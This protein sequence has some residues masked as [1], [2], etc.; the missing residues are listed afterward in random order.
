[1]LTISDTMKTALEADNITP[2]I[3]ITFDFP[4]TIS[5]GIGPGTF[6]D[7]KKYYTSAPAAI[8]FTKISGS[9]ETI[10]PSGIV[11]YQ[12]PQVISSFDRQIT[13]IGMNDPEILLLVETY[14]NGVKVTTQLFLLDPDNISFSINE[15]DGLV[16]NRGITS[17]HTIGTASRTGRDVIQVRVVAISRLNEARTRYTTD[18]SQRAIYPYDSAFRFIAEPPQNLNTTW[19]R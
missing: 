3:I 17:G 16:V 4:S 8:K 18:K 11:A 19:G 12:P 9:I 13:T 7:Q 14:P 15:A 2:W 6:I 10:Q 1:M 5:G